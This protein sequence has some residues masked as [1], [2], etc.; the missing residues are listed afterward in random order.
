MCSRSA[1]EQILVEDDTRGGAEATAEPRSCAAKG[2]ELKSL[3]E[4]VNHGFYTLAASFVN[5]VPLE[6]LNG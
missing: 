6:H 1:L 5:S 4:T 3:L 2:E